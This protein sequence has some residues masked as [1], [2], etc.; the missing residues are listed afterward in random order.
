MISGALRP[1]EALRARWSEVDLDKKRLVLPKERMKSKREHIVPLSS[2]ALEVLERRDRDRVRTG[3]E[4]VDAAA[5]V[6]T[7]ERGRPLNYT[8]FALAPKRMGVNSGSPHSW[9]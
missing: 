6:F 1:S 5:L 8:L 7:G 3:D 2:I 9:R 4:R